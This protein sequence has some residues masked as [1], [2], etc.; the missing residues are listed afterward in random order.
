[1]FDPF[2]IEDVL[3]LRFHQF[4]QKWSFFLFGLLSIIVQMIQIIWIAIL[5]L[6]LHENFFDMPRLHMF[7]LKHGSSPVEVNKF[8]E[9]M[10][11]V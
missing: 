3:K 7:Y 5:K 9:F 10:S 11:I 4:L 8:A 6:F 2:D 1:M